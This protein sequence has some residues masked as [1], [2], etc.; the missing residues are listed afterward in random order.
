MLSAAKWG[1]LVGVVS[2]LVVDIV[3]TVFAELVTGPA[4]AGLD[5]NSGK[6]G[7]VIVGIFLLLFAFSAAGY[8]TGRETARAGLG[9]IAGMIALIFY[10]IPHSLYEPFASAATSST[11][12]TTTV[13][14]PALSPVAV[15]IVQLI[16][17]AIVLSIGACM[18]WLGGRPGA[19][20]AT[21]ATA[22]TTTQASAPSAK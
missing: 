1:A 8:F 22:I 12:T 9:A 20:R 6:L 7:F 18:G 13:N 21:K 15:A 14:Q 19:Q 5:T 2:Y 3:L 10:A 11:T 4:P 17:L 16:T